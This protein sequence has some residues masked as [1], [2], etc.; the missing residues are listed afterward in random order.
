MTDLQLQSTITCPRC[1]QKPLD[2][3]Q[4]IIVSIFGSALTAKIN[5]NLKKEIVVFIV[6]MELIHVHQNRFKNE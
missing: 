2:K 3:C 5:L 1:H 6:L 4:P